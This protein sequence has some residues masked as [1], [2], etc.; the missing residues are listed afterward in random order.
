MP[1]LLLSNNSSYFVS[2]T[3]PDLARTALIHDK[4]HGSGSDVGKGFGSIG[5]GG[6][7]L[8]SGSGLGS[9]LAMKPLTHGRAYRLWRPKFDSEVVTVILREY[10]S[11]LD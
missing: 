11:C 3:S 8:A 10:C 4:E 9:G 7:G 1:Q 6:F 5:A 2:K